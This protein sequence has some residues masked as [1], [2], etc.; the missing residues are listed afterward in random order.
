[1]RQ[2]L[3]TPLD[4]FLGQAYNYDDHS[5][6]ENWMCSFDDN[7]TSSASEDDVIKTQI[8][9][10]M[11]I[12]IA[13]VTDRVCTTSGVLKRDPLQLGT[14]LRETPVW[15]IDCYTR[16]MIELSIADGLTLPST[17]TTAPA[18]ASEPSAPDQE[19]VRVFIERKVLPTINSLPIEAA[20]SMKAVMC[21][22]LE[23]GM[24]AV[25]V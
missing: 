5:L 21:A 16:R 11:D 1:M 17:S 25:C 23:V 2:Y 13:Q 18:T 9:S 3:V 14:S 4:G 6:T 7:V 15:G 24:S 12:M 20:H 22:I 19:V 8:E 10:L